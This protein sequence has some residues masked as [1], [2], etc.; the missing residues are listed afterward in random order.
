MK[1]FHHFA[2][3]ILAIKPP[4]KYMN[5]TMLGNCGNVGACSTL[6]HQI[7]LE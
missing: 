7:A 1:Y 4:Y 2:P 3:L 5:H 6:M